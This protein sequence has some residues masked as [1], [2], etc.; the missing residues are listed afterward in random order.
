VYN[1]ETGGCFD[2][3]APEKVNM[4]Q[5][6]ESSISYLLARLKLEDLKQGVWKQKRA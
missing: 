5:G 1:P 3:I 6:A 4:N 2:G